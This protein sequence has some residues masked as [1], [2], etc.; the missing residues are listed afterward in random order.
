MSVIFHIVGV[1]ALL[2]VVTHFVAG[3]M[4]ASRSGGAL[5]ITVPISIAYII[6]LIL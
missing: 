4:R 1:I 6:W 5:G 3:D 2:Q